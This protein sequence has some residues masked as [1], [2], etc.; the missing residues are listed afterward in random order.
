MG[1]GDADDAPLRKRPDSRDRDRDRHRHRKHDRDRER[2]RRR[3]RIDDSHGN[4]RGPRRRHG[5]DEL[6]EGSTKNEVED[7]DRRD[8]D[9]RSRGDERSE[10][11]ER[12]RRDRRDRERRRSQSPESS[13]TRHRREEKADTSEAS[14]RRRHS[15]RERDH[16][17]DR[18]R[19]HRRRSP[20][21]REDETRH[22]RRRRRRDEESE[23]NS[24]DE[25]EVVIRTE[26]DGRSG[27]H[28][29]RPV[30]QRD[31]LPDQ[32]NAFALVRPGGGGGGDGGDKT[33]PPKEQPNLAPTGVLA[34]ASRAVTQ[35]D[36]SVVTLKYHEPP[37]ARKPS[38]ARDP[39][40]LFVFKEGAIVDTV[41][42]HARSCWLVGR[43][44]AVV[45]LLAAHPSVSKQHAVLQF[46][47]VETRNEFGDRL[48]RV[49]PYVLD[50]ASA[51]GTTLNGTAVPAQRYVELRA[52][53]LVQFGHSAREYV[54]MRGNEA[55]SRADAT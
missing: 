16:D 23:D 49:A 18:D 29:A 28:A 20:D 40:T 33:P 37:E 42:L 52:R 12:H 30:Q 24:D 2:D 6:R 51:N 3:D 19:D 34:A 5:D 1:L 55:S 43:D 39:W 54:L 10:R 9:R 14:D 32:A 41:P 22:R 46:R 53:D 36:G 15:H 47:Y 13:R 21:E 31:P 7:R 45:D 44:A 25:D 17:R 26:R 8:R 38:A 11:D 35:A 4:D 48:G 50:L 27:S